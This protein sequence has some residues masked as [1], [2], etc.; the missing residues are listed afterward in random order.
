MDSYDDKRRHLI[1]QAMA[2]CD[3]VESNA[4]NHRIQPWK[5][6]AGHLSPLIGESG[7]SALYRR[8]VRLASGE[9]EWLNAPQASTTA[10][11]LLS[12]LRSQLAAED[13]HQATAA[14]AALLATFTKLLSGLIGE[15]LTIRLL[16]A[17]WTDADDK[18]NARDPS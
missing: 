9:H 16:Q 3:A 11:E 18:P 12:A 7:F 10:D 5:Q 17:A 15:A 6:L 8:A 2:A 13:A 4:G 14:N 1:A